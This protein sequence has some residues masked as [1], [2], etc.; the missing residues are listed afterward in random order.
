MSLD[1]PGFRHRMGAFSGRFGG[2]I[3]AALEYLASGISMQTSS[4]REA[5]LSKLPY[6][7]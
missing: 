6:L 4:F 3:E 7:Q 1:G 5:S 2:T